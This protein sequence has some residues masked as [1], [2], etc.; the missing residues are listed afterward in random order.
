MKRRTFI[1]KAGA[2]AAGVVA[3][4]YILPSGR[5][6]ASTGARLVNHVVYVVFGGGIRNQESVGQQYLA[7]QGLVT[8]GN[9]MENMLSGVAPSSNIVYDQW[10]PVL[11]TKLAQQGTLL[12]KMR[13]STG[14]TG[15]YNAHAVA[16]T[17]SYISTGI[18]VNVN[19]DVPT[20]FEFYRKHT[21]PSKSAIN[22]WWLSEGLGPYPSLNYSKHP[23]YGSSYGANYLNAANLFSAQATA[24]L[25]NAKNYHPDELGKINDIKGFLDNN[26]KDVAGGVGVQNTEEN[27]ENIKQ[28]ILDAM[29]DF[30][31]G[32]GEVATP[33]SNYALLTG[34]LLN[35]S[36][37]WRVLDTF[38]PELT[39]INTTN[40]DVCHDDFTGYI[41]FLHKAD[42]GI[43][44]L[45]DKIQN[46]PVLKDDTI[47]ICMP[48]HG[49][50]L[51]PN[52]IY[53]SNGFRAYDHNSD[54]NSRDVF[55]LIAGPTG[56]VNQG[57]EFD[58]NDYPLSGAALPECIDIVPTIANILG[59]GD[60]IPQGFL[61]GRNLGEA[62]V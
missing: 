54:D 37:S 55:A 9:I 62:F 30:G 23:L 36:A 6:F 8:Q 48:E 43:G 41:D 4:P 61:T 27:R 25:S 58:E 5:L 11:S 60:S 10:A 59:F 57:T 35:I 21:D 16:M 29:E 53:D 7:N 32:T 20:L 45:W 47:M 17:G 1:R 2:V 51:E 56:V 38:A 49:R 15:H 19:P 39:V 12:K 18:N 3:A 52:T 42:Y 31:G 24:Y 26:F 22:A 44:W 50:N 14:N 28:F 34:D 46:H 33:G 13:Y 40:L